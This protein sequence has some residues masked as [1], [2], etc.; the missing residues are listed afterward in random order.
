MCYRPQIMIE[1][2]FRLSIQ[3]NIHQKGLANNCILSL[4]QFYPTS[5]LFLESGWN[6]LNF[7]NTIHTNLFVLKKLLFQIQIFICFL[8]SKHNC[9]LQSFPLTLFPFLLL[10]F[11]SNPPP[12][13]NILFLPCMCVHAASFHSYPLVLLLSRVCAAWASEPYH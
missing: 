11:S 10:V 8:F 2:F 7:S 1:K 6:L 5:Q 13:F 9:V 3:I 4:F 12:V